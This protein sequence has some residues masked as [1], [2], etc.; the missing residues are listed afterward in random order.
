MIRLTRRGSSSGHDESDAASSEADREPDTHDA[1]RQRLSPVHHAN[2]P[3]SDDA[4]PDLKASRGSFP[5]NRLVQLRL[6]HQLLQP[7]VLTLQFLQTLC[8]IAADTPVL[9]SPAIVRVVRHTDLTT[10]LGDIPTL[11]S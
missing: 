6:G 3:R 5:E 7:G 8:P 4:S 1:R 9:L 11:S 10:G 2:A